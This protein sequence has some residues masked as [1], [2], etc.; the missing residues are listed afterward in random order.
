MKKIITYS[1][2]FRIISERH[3]ENM[4]ANQNHPNKYHENQTLEAQPLPVLFQR[5]KKQAGNGPSRRHI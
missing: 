2:Q 1:A 3:S 5:N 4:S